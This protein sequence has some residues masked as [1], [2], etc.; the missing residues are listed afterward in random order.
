MEEAK[1]SLDAS[2]FASEL[3]ELQTIYEVDRMAAQKKRQ[4]VVLLFSVL[5]CALLLLVVIVFVVYYNRLRKKNQSLYEQINSNLRNVGSSA[6]VLQ[7]IPE[8]ELSREM[9]MFR[10]ISCLMDEE[11]L[12]GILHSI[13]LYW[14]S[15]WEP[16]R[17]MWQMPSGKGLERPCRIILRIS[18]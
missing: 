10:R 18:G 9:Q 7:M 13:A 1:D 11:N 16:T 15:F 14:R 8:E 3:S 2:R 12:T 6:K 4:Q 5:C 17:S